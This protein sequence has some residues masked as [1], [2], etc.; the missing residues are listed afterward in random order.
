MAR[1]KG[2][3]IGNNPLD[4]VVPMGQAAKPA[5]HGMLEKQV[6]QVKREKV[7]VALPGDLMERLRAAAYWTRKP[8]A[9]LVEEGVRAAIQQEE[10]A[11]GEPFPPLAE[12]LRPGR[13]VG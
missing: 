6:L 11:H 2:S 10:K 12:K 13:K 4:A 9:G 7:T 8:L 5:N 1:P 3:T